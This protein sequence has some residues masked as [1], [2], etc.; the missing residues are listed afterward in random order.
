MKI[1]LLGHGNVGSGVSA[2]IDKGNTSFTEQLKIKKILVKDESEATDER[3]VFNIDDALDNDIDIVVEC[4]GGLK[5][6][7]LASLKH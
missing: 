7:L 2:I 6:P 5:F 3:M 4:L 1:A